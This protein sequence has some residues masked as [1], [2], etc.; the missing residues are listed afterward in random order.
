LDGRVR[1][2]FSGCMCD[3]WT[4][5]GGDS[6]LESSDEEIELNGEL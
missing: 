4:G 6:D 3:W 2:G 1:S 5:G